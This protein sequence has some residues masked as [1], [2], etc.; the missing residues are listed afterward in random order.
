[1]TEAQ[2]MQFVSQIDRFDYNNGNFVRVYFKRPKDIKGLEQ[3]FAEMGITDIVQ[4]KSSKMSGTTTDEYMF[5]LKYRGS[6]QKK[7]ID[8]LEQKN[9]R[10]KAWSVLRSWGGIQMTAAE[11]A[12][13]AKKDTELAATK[14]KG[15]SK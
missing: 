9:E 4:E 5:E 11:R 7:I 2:I 1:M 15:I 3:A 8:D 12:Y 13:F 10:I 6:S 14:F